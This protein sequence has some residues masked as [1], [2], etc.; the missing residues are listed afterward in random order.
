MELLEDFLALVYRKSH[1]QNTKESARTAMRRFEK[2]YQETYDKDLIETTLAIKHNSRDP[3]K[4]LDEFITWLDQQ[5]LRASTIH[6]WVS[7]AR[8]FMI[9]N[10]IGYPVLK[11]R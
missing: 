2:F 11:A 9:H 6:V 10:D 7:Y 5:N 4:V 3:Y 1:V 8:Q